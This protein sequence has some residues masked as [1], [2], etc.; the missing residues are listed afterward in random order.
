M[1]FRAAFDLI[2]LFHTK[3]SNVYATP[4][5][6]LTFIRPNREN[7]A[8]AACISGPD[9]FNLGQWHSLGGY[10]KA[11]GYSRLKQFSYRI[12][13]PLHRNTTDPAS[14]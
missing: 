8:W 9:F 6:A 1:G 7:G 2:I 5:Q 11:T 12:L 10:L 4:N 14:H 3:R 13:K